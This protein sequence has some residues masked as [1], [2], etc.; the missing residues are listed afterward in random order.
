MTAGGAVLHATLDDNPT[1]RDFAALL[2]LTLPMNDLF[3]R[4]KYAHLPRS[5]AAGGEPRSSYEIGNI[6]YWSPG[7]DIAIFYD[8]DGEFI[9]APGII[10]LGEID[11]GAG[12][13]QKYDGA[14]DV[15]VEAA[16]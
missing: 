7:P 4:E 6:A 11:S 13:L 5:L 14:V 10:V 8:Q 2:P 9:P 15:T 3:K 12:A 16:D 1:A